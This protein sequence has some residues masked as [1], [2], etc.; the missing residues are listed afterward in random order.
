MILLV[1]LTSS[2]SKFQCSTMAAARGR[3]QY[4]SVLTEDPTRGKN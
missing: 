4:A 1:A 2:K 3:R